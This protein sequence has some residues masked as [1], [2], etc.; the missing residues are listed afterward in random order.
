MAKKKLTEEEKKEVKRLRT[1]QSLFFVLI[2]F[3]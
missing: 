2:T 3:L 1:K